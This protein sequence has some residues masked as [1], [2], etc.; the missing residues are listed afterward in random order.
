MYFQNLIAL[1]KQRRLTTDADEQL[2][3]E[4]GVE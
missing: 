1:V 2:G 3:R 4:P